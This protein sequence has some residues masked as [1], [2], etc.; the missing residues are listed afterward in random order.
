MMRKCK[1]VWVLLVILLAASAGARAQNAKADPCEKLN[2]Q[3][4]LNDCYGKAYQ[5]DD[6]RLNRIYHKAMESLQHDLAQ[7]GSDQ[8]QKQSAQ[9]A[10]DD[11]KAAELAWIKYRDLQCEAASQQY[12][13]GTMASMIHSICMSMA[14]EHRIDE[15]KQAYEND[16]RKLE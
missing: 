2:S 10:I 16:N 13:G 6:A 8:A 5:K 12:Q 14:T 1:T 11:L 7:A 9:A 4:E 3:A 15:I